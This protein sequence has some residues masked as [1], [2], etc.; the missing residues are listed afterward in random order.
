MIQKNI[1]IMLLAMSTLSAAAQQDEEILL[2]DRPTTITDVSPYQDKDIFFT[3]GEYYDEET[4]DYVYSMGSITL[5]AP[6]EPVWRINKFYLPINYW[7]YNE[8]Y[9]WETGKS[10]GRIYE[11]GVFLNNRTAVEAREIE[12]FFFDPEYE[13]WMFFS[14]PYDVN[15]SE[16]HGG[17]G[18]WVIRRYDSEARAAARAG[19]T[20]VDVGPGETLKAGEGYIFMRD[21]NG[22]Q[23]D[24]T[25]DWDEVEQ[26][27]L[28]YCLG[29]PAAS[30]ANKQNLFRSGDVVLPLRHFPAKTSTN[31]DWNMLG[32][33]F[34]SYYDVRA[35]PE[36]AVLY[37]WDYN[38]G[39][40]RTLS[41]Q[42]QNEVVLAPGQP[43]FVQA[44][45]LSQLT[46][47]TSGRLIEGPIEFE[48]DWS[49]D[50]DD[51]YDMDRAGGVTPNHV[52]VGHATGGVIPNQIRNMASKAVRKAKEKMKAMRKAG[53]GDFNPQSPPDPGANYYNALTGEAVFDMMQPNGLMMA[54]VQL[55]GANDL[56][57]NV[58]KVTV[59]TN[60]GE[61]FLF[62]LFTDCQ[63]VDLSQAWG[64]E[65]VPAGAFS[66]MMN[67]YEVIL[68]PCVEEIDALAFQYCPELKQI[69][70]YNPT[71][72]LVTEELFSNMVN[73]A[74]NLV[75]RVPAG[76]VEAYKQANVWRTKNIQA[77]N[78]GQQ[79]LQG[80]TLCVVAPDGTDLTSSCN[81]LWTAPNGEVLGAGGTLLAQT[82]GNVVHYSIGLQPKIADLYVPVPQGTWTV[83]EGGNQITVSLEPTGVIDMGS[84]QL[85]GSAG[86]LEITFTPSD[87][88]APATFNAN[89]VKLTATDLTTGAVLDD[90]VVGYLSVN[91]EHTILKPGQMIELSA[92]SR[93]GSFAPATAQAM[94]D[95]DGTFAA[96]MELKEYG[97]AQINCRPDIGVT[98]FMALIF[99]SAGRFAA[100]YNADGSIIRIGPMP[101]GNYQAAVMEQTPYLNAIATLEDL[102]RTSLRAGTDY[103]MLEIRLATGSTGHYEVDVHGLDVFQIGHITAD[104]YITT[105]DAELSITAI[106]TVRSK[107]V[108][109]PEMAGQVTGV[110]LILDIP[111]GMEYVENS[112]ICR[113]GSFQQ[114]G[115]RIIIP[116]S[117]GEQMKLCLRPTRSG[118]MTIPA[119][120][121]YI[122]GGRQYVQPIGSATIQVTGLSLDVARITNRA[123]LTVRGFAFAN[124][125]VTIYDGRNIVG[126]T[127]AKADGFYSADITL[128][129]AYDGTLHR[130]S[131][132]VK[133]PNQPDMQTETA[134]V[135]FDREASMLTHVSMVFQDQR[136]TWNELTGNISPGY[137]NVVPD[138]SD[139]ATFA[140]RLDNS[141]PECIM[142]P[143]FD[144]LASD[145][146]RRT[147]D[148]TW[149]EAT[150]TYTATASYPDIFSTP[151]EVQFIYSYADSTAYSRRE[152]FEAEVNALI[153]A[154]NQLVEGVE[155]AVEVGDIVTDDGETLATELIVGGQDRYLMTMKME[156]YERV[157]AQRD[158]LERPIIRTVMG[159]DTVTTYFIV[160]GERRTTVYF[161]N[162]TQRE[163]YSET[164]ET[165]TAAAKA[166]RISWGGVLGKVK[167]WLSPTPSNLLSI[168]EK[169]DQVNGKMDDANKV[170]EALHYI[171]EMQARYD[172]YN[173]DLSNRINVLQY[174]LM[175]RCPDG[176][177]R[178]KPELYSRFQGEIRRL[179][180]QRKVF[181][182]QM[183]NLILSYCNALENCGYKEIAKEL[184]KFTAK[185]LAKQKLSVKSGQLAEKM[186]MTGMGTAEEFGSLLDNGIGKGIDYIVD[187]GADL[188]TRHG[189]ISTDFAGVK[190]LF[191]E[192]VPG[193]YHKISMQVTD[194]KFTIQNA[195]KECEHKDI[196]R[197]P[198]PWAKIKRRVRPMVDPSGYVYE[199]IAAN[200]VEGVTATIYYKKNSGEGEQEW[201]ADNYGQMNPQVTD[202]QGTYMWNVPKGLWQVRFQKEGY[203][204]A[205][206][207]WL[208]VPPPQLDIAV[209]MVEHA[210]PKVT[211]AEATAEAV[212]LHFSKYMKT[213]SLNGISVKQEGSALNGTIEG[214]NDENGLASHFRFLPAQPITATQVELIV[215]VE[216]M[217]YSGDMMAEAFDEDVPV[218]HTIESLIVQEGAAIELGMTGYVQVA[219]YPA[220][221]VAGRTLRVSSRSPLLELGEVDVAFDEE[222]QA[223]VPFKGLLPGKA[224]VTF[225]VADLEAKATVEVKYHLYDIVAIP[226]PN[227]ADGTVVGEGSSV[228][229]F[230]ATDDAVIYYTTD[231][232]CPCDPEHRILYTGPLPI[233]GEITIQAIAVRE[234]MEDSEVVTLHYSVGDGLAVDEVKPEAIVSGQEWYDMKGQRV[235][236][237][238]PRGIYIRVRRTPQGPRSQKILITE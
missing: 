35:I 128:Y 174:F 130:L 50:W 153:A 175:A 61:Y 222:G 95:Q 168:N 190:R 12:T 238:L 37:V 188:I 87:A 235:R 96:R 118:Q 56:Y 227:I 151:A 189:H 70:L 53:G 215:P 132:D 7:N 27:G 42:D 230:T 180:E 195:Y 4:F 167:G 6:A 162:D 211:R 123:E 39:E 109:R 67:L 13:N 166:R 85:R 88:E 18:R 73:D 93:S 31:A 233:T 141:K 155:K 9:N 228:E 15:V 21:Y 210:A 23:N 187:K 44:G 134:T 20:W 81:I 80:V 94:A 69:D 169:I 75:I 219:A 127:I 43:F 103:S 225:A 192:F 226:I 184:A 143:Y 204:T 223:S 111:D 119:Q 164:I 193:E 234:G 72:P 142:D 163:A 3:R 17:L 157:W 125:R 107:V 182:K 179:D 92:T 197:P 78:G 60:L 191:E 170:L 173:N 91:F 104:T 224:D 22:L 124:S 220:Q 45:E 1:A 150:Q 48:E 65:K 98:D 116:Y 110:Q 200:R 212:S 160:E 207:E 46:F 131:A 156:D 112:L 99:D 2:V 159:G 19:E 29:L 90:L 140:A 58:R 221:A 203:E 59:L 161:A 41:T 33:P 63:T 198:V 57:R 77:L 89:D 206:T 149:N 108:F 106:G 171:D 14:V 148:A 126:Q 68:P 185:F 11:I 64:F 144:V 66:F 51:D 158:E 10:T 5:D 133:T 122:L 181:T 79:Q 47:P 152:L 54:A 120:V 137:Y 24:E 194:L 209:P 129:P 232:S 101:D 38:S 237:P 52:S 217:S 26:T 28:E 82:V 178:L 55:L 135:F 102:E 100:R 71:P 8:R 138:M 114:T 97:R 136:V 84:R 176:S 76:A 202:Q 214:V 16:L 121:Q 199:G 205:Q 186:A 208:P 83:Q 36:K 32:N 165:Q 229:L 117:T 49:D 218:R 145:G 40:F 86:T 236:P 139:I 154:H 25:I 34:A 74:D 105:S 172:E 231:G 216:V 62:T 113:T 115:R 183:Q 201:D 30:T 213:A 177:L 196:V 146:T 147:L